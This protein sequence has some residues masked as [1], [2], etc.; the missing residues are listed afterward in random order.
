LTGLTAF[1]ALLRS[2][3]GDS[4]FSLRQLSALLADEGVAL[5]PPALVRIEAGTLQRP[6]RRQT[7][8]AL[9]AVL[10]VPLHSWLAALYQTDQ[11]SAVPICLARRSQPKTQL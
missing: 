3:R 4:H 5:S 10:G 2:A 1:G 6:P 11:G 9:S 7:L 8:G